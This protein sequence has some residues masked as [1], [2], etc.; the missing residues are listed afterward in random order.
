MTIKE[1]IKNREKCLEYLEGAGVG[2]DPECVEAVR[3]SVTALRAQQTSAKP[4]RSRWEGCYTCNNIPGIMLGAITMCIGK[5]I[6]TTRDHDFKFCPE[7]GRP[8]TEEAWADLER[9]IND[10]TTYI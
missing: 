3:M 1:A 9:R 5:R 7:C 2:A 10:G 6:L 4:D 8:L